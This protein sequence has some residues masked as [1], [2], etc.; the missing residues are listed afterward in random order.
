MP[1]TTAAIV[2]TMRSVLPMFFVMTI[3]LCGVG[4]CGVFTPLFIHRLDALWLR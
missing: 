2:R 3:L 4:K 1:M